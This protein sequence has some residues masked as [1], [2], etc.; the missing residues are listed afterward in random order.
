MLH[1]FPLCDT[2]MVAYRKKNE[3]VIHI[4]N[5]N[6]YPNVSLYSPFILTLKLMRYRC[7]Q[8]NVG[9]YI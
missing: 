4:Y 1:H 5:G 3:E 6:A 2:N 7:G 8:K 9:L